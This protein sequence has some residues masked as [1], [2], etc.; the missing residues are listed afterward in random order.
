MSRKSWRLSRRTFL[1]G[2][3]AA[4]ALPWLESMARGGTVS[5]LAAPKPPV[6]FACL[7]FP[8]GAWMKNWTPDKT[9]VDYELP[10]SLS[11]LAEVKEQVLVLSGLDKKNSHEGD[12]HYAKTAN[13]LTGLHVNK[14]IGRDI[15]AGGTSMDQIAAQKVGTTTPLPSL[16]LG[17]DPIVSGV[18]ANVGYTRLYASYIAWRAPNVPVAR[19]INPR[20]VYE[21]LFGAKD[22]NGKP[23]AKTDSADDD[24]S[25]LDAALGDAKDLRGR[26]GRDDQVKMD[27]YLESVRA[28]ER[29][30]AFATKTDQRHW[31]PESKPELSAPDS[32]IP[33]DYQKHVQLMLDLI[34]LAFWTDQT[35]IATFMFAN[36]VSNR[37]FSSYI[38]GVK[39][40][41]HQLSHH[42][43]KPEKQQQYSMINR[44]HAAQY[45]RMLKKMAAVKEGD[46]NLLENSMIL[47]G[48]GMSDGNRHDPANL[49]IL[50]GGKGGGTLDTGRHVAYS[51][52]TPL[53]NLHLS[54]LDR[55]GVEIPR[56]G[57]STG[58]LAALTV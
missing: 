26:L 44:W 13:F 14:T 5:Q 52:G 41:H 17:I 55:M 11:P 8:N 24:R 2:T 15:S 6:R 43:N 21:R 33:S 37:N 18:D 48:S 10:Y 28:V 32:K 19:E 56:F 7:Y 50:I 3:G 4:I 31:H 20:A 47:M 34:V 27:E 45:A 42:E 35:R 57:D 51:Q 30:I 23:I 1:R 46:G 40:G 12:G 29:Q 49:P 22:A 38:D 58:R 16:E 53:C 9:G 39:G 25:L 36:D 54:I